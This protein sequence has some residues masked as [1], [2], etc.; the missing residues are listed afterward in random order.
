MKIHSFGL[1]SELKAFVAHGGS[2]AA[3][4]GDTDD[5]VMATLLV[6]RMLQV[7][8]DYHYNLEEHIRDHDEIIQPLPFF[9][10]FS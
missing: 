8:S 4:I 6:V 2:Y 10:S 7:L 3:K 1:I 9:A 5:L